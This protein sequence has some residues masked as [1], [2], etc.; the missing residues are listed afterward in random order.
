MFESLHDLKQQWKF[1]KTKIKHEDKNSEI[2]RIRFKQDILKDKEEIANKI[3]ICFSKLGLY[4][5]ETEMVELPDCDFDK[6]KFSFRH[7]TKKVLLL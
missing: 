6:T 5:G 4:E 7:I 2:S 3:N 1:I